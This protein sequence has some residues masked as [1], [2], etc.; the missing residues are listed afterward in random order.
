MTE[1]DGEGVTYGIKELKDL[2]K[3]RAVTASNTTKN[4]ENETTIDYQ[5][6]EAM[7]S[8]RRAISL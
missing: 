8:F 6:Q 7:I 3:E 4:L 5:H 2:K 1:K